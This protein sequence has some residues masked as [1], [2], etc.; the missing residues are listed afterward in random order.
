MS[1]IARIAIAAAAVLVVAVVGIN[2]FPSRNPSNVGVPN[3]SPSPTPS[4]IL[5]PADGSSGLGPME[6][7]AYVTDG[8]WADV[9]VMLPV[10]FTVPEGWGNAGWAI[11]RPPGAS[12]QFTAKA[13][14]AWISFGTVGQTYSDP[15]K[16]QSTALDPP[17]GPTV[18]DFVTALG[19]QV[20][21]NATTPSAATIDGFSGQALQ[22]EIPVGID[23]PNCEGR[24]YRLWVAPGQ[25][26]PARN[27]GNLSGLD[28][29]LWVLDVNGIRLVI[30]SLAPMAATDA[31]RSEAEAIVESI[32]F[33]PIEAE[34]ASPTPGSTIVPSP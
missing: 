20:G 4:P 8:D 18:Q 30:E 2:V 21:S 9:N 24:E 34:G 29:R 28:D 14:D 31:Q 16:Y 10:I 3:P 25:G 19:Q 27:T 22:I 17:L 26:D 13:G 6:P 32:H 33:G 1:N 7:G 11:E 12:S 5:L 23:A 15:C